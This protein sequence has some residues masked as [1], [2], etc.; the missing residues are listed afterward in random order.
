MGNH[1]D[2]KKIVIKFNYESSEI[3]KIECNINDKLK[4]AINKFAKMKNVE[5][6]NL[7]FLYNG[8]LLDSDESISNIINSSDKIS[9][10]INILAYLNNPESNDI[11]ILLIIDSQTIIKLKGKKD[12]ILETILQKE[13]SIISS[14]LDQFEILYKDTNINLDKTFEDIADE[15]DKSI[16]RLIIYAN[17]KEKFAVKFINDKLEE[18]I[19]ICFPNDKMDDIIKK[20]C[21]ENGNLN[22]NYYFFKYENNDNIFGKTINELYNDSNELNNNNNLTTNTSIKNISQ[23]NT[24]FKEIEIKV[25]EKSCWQKH[26]VI[27][28]SSTISILFSGIIITIGYIYGQKKK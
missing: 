7:I 12:D 18:K 21:C 11:N 13:N 27:I 24:E 6:T 2:S 5:I 4:K 22:P 20:Y 17:H 3:I 16:N 9:G 25:I 1:N 8:K 19:Q 28:I 26:K 15:Y 10:E 23:T 14:N